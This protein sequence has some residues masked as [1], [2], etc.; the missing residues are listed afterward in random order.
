MWRW[1]AKQQLRLRQR[2]LVT[3]TNSLLA[4]G[5]PVLFTRLKGLFAQGY[6]L[7]E[8]EHLEKMVIKD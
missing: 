3:N 7:S 4:S 8:M 6:Q 2:K 5:L 1:P